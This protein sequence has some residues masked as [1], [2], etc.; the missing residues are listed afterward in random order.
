MMTEGHLSAC[1][2][3]A[4]IGSSLAHSG[5]RLKNTH[6]VDVMVALWSTGYTSIDE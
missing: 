5:K 3:T 6:D 1:L 2:G 4:C